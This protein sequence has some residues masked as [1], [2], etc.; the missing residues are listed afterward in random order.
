M[1]F[2]TLLAMIVIGFFVLY[3]VFLA[4]AALAHFFFGVPLATDLL[5]YLLRRKTGIIDVGG[6]EVTFLHSKPRIRGG[7]TSLELTFCGN[8][9]ARAVF[10]SESG[11]DQLGKDYGLN[12]EIQL[13]DPAFDQAVYVECDDALFVGRLLGPAEAKE[14]LKGLLE[15]FTSFELKGSSCVLTMT[16]CDDFDGMSIRDLQAAAK[17]MVALADR[18]PPA[19]PGQETR[20]PLTDSL[21]RTEQVYKAGAVSFALCGS[22]VAFWGLQAFEPVQPWSSF[23]ASLVPA[24]TV[25]LIFLAHIYLRFKGTSTG[26]RAFKKSLAFG[27]AGLAL[28]CWG[29]LLVLNGSQDVSPVSNH[30]VNVISKQANS[31]KGGGFTLRL[32]SWD[33]DFEV[34]KLNV[35][36]KEF[37]LIEVGDTC[38]IS[39]K[40]GFLDLAWIDG[41]LCRGRGRTLGSGNAGGIVIQDTWRLS[42]GFFR[43]I[44]APQPLTPLYT[45]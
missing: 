40:K 28:W 11:T 7:R 6:R 39:V 31:G 37:E 36:R 12:R 35:R 34:Y 27:G 4:A 32:S 1:C 26:L 16:P 14:K 33:K 2:P 19:G 22:L 42:A 38:V 13:N 9:N 17:D 15:R 21:R 24:L 18:I 44:P 5:N 43:E 8:F 10:R 45:R 23:R 41:K 29:W 30:E 25:G 20:T 3:L